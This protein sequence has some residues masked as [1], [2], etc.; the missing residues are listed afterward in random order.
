LI[1]ILQEPTYLIIYPFLFSLYP[2]FHLYSINYEQYTSYVIVF[3]IMV[4]LLSSALL[5]FLL[6]KLLKDYHRA[7]ALLLIV[8]VWFFSY[9]SF[10]SL[11]GFD[12]MGIKV[13]RHQYLIVFWLILLL[14]LVILFIKIRSNYRKVTP[15]LNIVCS[16]LIIFSLTP[17]AHAYFINTTNKSQVKDIEPIH[18]TPTNRS[19][20]TG[21]LPDIYYIILDSYTGSKALKDYLNFDNS[22]FINNLRKKGFYVATDSRSNYAWTTYSIASALNMQY[23][24]MKPDKA[25]PAYLKFKDDLDTSKLITNNE[26]LTIL[27]SIGYSYIDLSIWGRLASKAKGYYE[28]Q[29]NIYN[30]YYNTEFYIGLIKMTF[31]AIPLAENYLEGA[32]KIKEIIHKFDLLETIP[33][34]KGPAFTYAHF[35]IPHHPYVFDQFGNDIG[36]LSQVFPINK[37]KLYLNQLMY[38]NA[39]IEK[40]IDSILARPGPPPLIIVQGDHGAWELGKNINENMQM[41]M[42]ILNAYYLPKGGATKLYNSIT[43][44]NTFRIIFNNYFGGKYPLL[45]DKSYYN[46]DTSGSPLIAVH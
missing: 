37:R 4:L 6:G 1:K 42:S 33:D 34:V 36:L 45:P 12:I 9:A 25:N 32:I 38:A 43:P 7:A 2:V 40:I 39:Q 20:R 23:L 26:V 44:V 29:Q 16:C 46:G 21:E 24:P 10:R 17:L 31:L 11:M 8:Q 14:I 28:Y 22:K 35:L 15:P 5:L 13:Y 41:R 30:N 3:P 27:K 18:G 19:Q